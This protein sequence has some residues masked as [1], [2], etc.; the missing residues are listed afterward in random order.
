MFEEE[1]RP[2]MPPTGNQ[3]AAADARGKDTPA[4]S[5]EAQGMKAENLSDQKRVNYAF[6]PKKDGENESVAEKTRANAGKTAVPYVR[7][8]RANTAKTNAS[9]AEKNGTTDEKAGSPIPSEKVERPA[10]SPADDKF[11]TLD[12][13]SDPIYPLEYPPEYDDS[14]APA[15]APAGIPQNAEKPQT[16][17]EEERPFE[18][19]F[20]RTAPEA[21][22][23]PIERERNNAR[24][25]AGAAAVERSAREEE[26]RALLAALA[27]KKRGDDD[28]FLSTQR[29]GVRMSA[30]KGAYEKGD[31][32]LSEEYLKSR[33]AD[34]DLRALRE[35]EA[36]DILRTANEEIEK[37]IEKRQK[38]EEE[39]QNRHA[40]KK[41]DKDDDFFRVEEPSAGQNEEESITNKLTESEQK[42]LQ[43][44]KEREE[45]REDRKRRRLVMRAGDFDSFDVSGTASPKKSESDKP[46]D[47]L[48]L[49]DYLAKR[50]AAIR[51]DNDRKRQ[52]LS[53]KAQK[54]LRKKEKA[55]AINEAV[56]SLSALGITD[57][58]STQ[59]IAKSISSARNADEVYPSAMQTAGAAGKNATLTQRIEKAKQLAYSD[60]A[61]RYLQSVEEEQQNNRA[62]LRNIKEKLSEERRL[63]R[64]DKKSNPEFYLREFEKEVNPALQAKAKGDSEKETTEAKLTAILLALEDARDLAVET[65]E[66]L[67]EEA[68]DAKDAAEYDAYASMQAS[69]RAKIERDRVEKI[70][71]HSDVSESYRRKVE[72]EALRE[73]K[74]ANLDAKNAVKAEAV[75]QMKAELLEEITAE[76]EAR[77]F[78]LGAAEASLAAEAARVEAERIAESERNAAAAALAKSEEAGARLVHARARLSLP[79]TKAEKAILEKE[80][81]DAAEIQLRS[82]REA[83]ERS[84]KADVDEIKVSFAVAK[85]ERIEAD[86]L[87]RSARMLAEK[88]EVYALEQ[89]R[90]VGVADLDHYPEAENSA[91]AAR[92]EADR[93]F[94]RVRE[95]AVRAAKAA[96]TFALLEAAVAKKERQAAERAARVA[97][98]EADIAERAAKLKEE[99][100]IVALY[101]DKKVA[102]R[103]AK[104]ARFVA[105][106]KAES[107]VAQKARAAAAA[108]NELKLTAYA[109]GVEDERL[110]RAERD[111]EDAKERAR[112]L[113]DVRAE[114]QIRLSEKTAL[115]SAEEALAIMDTVAALREARLAE[116]ER[117]D[118]SVLRDE[119]EAETDEETSGEESAEEV[120]EQTPAE[121]RR[122]L[123]IAKKEATKEADKVNIERSEAR[124]EELFAL[125]LENKIAK[126]KERLRKEEIAN[127]VALRE[128]GERRLTEAKTLLAGALRVAEEKTAA[129]IRADK[130][131]R[132]TASVARKRSANEEKTGV[133]DRVKAKALEARVQAERVSRK[134]HSAAVASAAAEAEVKARLL[135]VEE[136][137]L[138]NEDRLALNE[139]SRELGELKKE[140]ASAEKA[141]AET[142]RDAARAAA[143]LENAKRKYEGAEE[144][145]NNAKESAERILAER[146]AAIAKEERDR[147]DRDLTDKNDENRKALARLAVL[148]AKEEALLAKEEERLAARSAG[149]ALKDAVYHAVLAERVPEIEKTEAGVQAEKCREEADRKEAENRKKTAKAAKAVSALAIAEEQEAALEAEITARS[150]RIAE[151]DAKND[152]SAAIRLDF[153]ADNAQ[154]DEKTAALRALRAQRE[155]ADRSHEI[156]EVER[157]RAKRAQEVAARCHEAALH[158]EEEYL[159][160]S[161]TANA[162]IRARAETEA[163]RLSER[164]VR[165]RDRLAKLNELERAKVLAGAET[166]VGLSNA[167][168]RRKKLKDGVRE[169]ARQR[170]GKEIEKTA[171]SSEAEE[172]LTLYLE[173][174]RFYPEVSASLREYVGPIN[175]KVRK[176]TEKL[177]ET[178]ENKKYVAAEREELK[179]FVTESTAALEKVRDEHRKAE[180]RAEEEIVRAQKFENTAKAEAKRA[181]KEQA[182]AFLRAEE[183]G[184][185]YSEQIGKEE[186][187]R[188]YKWMKEARAEAEEALRFAEEQALLAE[189]AEADTLAKTEKAERLKQE[190]QKLEK[191]A[192]VD[193]EAE[194]TALERDIEARYAKLLREEAANAEKKAQA[195]REAAD[196][197]EKKHKKALDRKERDENAE[198]RAKETALKKEQAQRVAKEAAF[199]ADY[200]EAKARELSAKVER[201]A[202]EDAA[203]EARLLA[204]TAQKT[205][206]L[207]E[208][209]V[210][211]A[212]GEAKGE[213]ERARKVAQEEAE[214]AEKF[215]RRE[216][217][218]AAKALKAETEVAASVAELRKKESERQKRLAE[219]DFDRKKKEEEAAAEALLKADRK[220]KAEKAKQ[221]KEAKKEAE[222]A[223]ERLEEAKRQEEKDR[224]KAEEAEK[225]SE[226]AELIRQQRAAEEEKRSRERAEKAAEKEREKQILAEK[227]EKERAEKEAELKARREALLRSVAEDAQAASEKARP[228]VRKA[229][230][231]EDYF[232]DYVEQDQKAKAAAKAFEW[233]HRIA[234]EE[235]E[236]A[237][238]LALEARKAAEDANNRL[239]AESEQVLEVI[240]S[241]RNAAKKAERRASLKNTKEALAKERRAEKAGAYLDNVRKGARKAELAAMKAEA[242]AAIRKER[243]DRLEEEASMRT[244]SE[245]DA[246]KLRLALAEVKEAETLTATIKKDVDMA[247]EEALIAEENCL[248][249]ENRLKAGAADADRDVLRRNLAEAENT[250][251]NAEKQLKNLETIAE[252]AKLSQFA[253]QAKADRVAAVIAAT[254]ARLAAERAKVAEMS[255]DLKAQALSGAAK[256]EAEN[257][258]KI[259]TAEVGRAE[260]FAADAEKKAV[261][262]AVAE[263]EAAERSARADRLEAERIARLVSAE[264]KDA[265]NVAN[266]SADAASKAERED[267][268]EAEKKARSD[269]AEAERREEAA[270]EAAKNAERK[271]DAEKQAAKA[272]S[273]A[274]EETKRFFEDEKKVSLER[275]KTA[276]RKVA[277]KEATATGIS[278]KLTPDERKDYFDVVFKEDRRINNA[279]AENREQARR[280]ADRIESRSRDAELTKR[281]AEFTDKREEAYRALLDARKERQLQE[282]EL[283]RAKDEAEAAK[284]RAEAEKE[285]LKNAEGDEKE[286]AQREAYFA[287]REAKRLERVAL[288]E[289]QK[290][291]R[292]ASAGALAEQTLAA[293]SAAAEAAWKDGEEE[294]TDQYTSSA[295]SAADKITLSDLAKGRIGIGDKTDAAEDFLLSYAARDFLTEDMNEKGKSRK[296]K[297]KPAAE[298]V[299]PTLFTTANT[300]A[301]LDTMAGG[302]MD[303]LSNPRQA[304]A[305]IADSYFEHVVSDML[306]EIEFFSISLEQEKKRIKKQ[307]GD[308]K[309][310]AAAEIVDLERA[311]C[312]KYFDIL[313]FGKEKNKESEVTKFVPK[314]VAEIRRY[315]A[316]VKA[317]EAL[318]HQKH[319]YASLKI[320]AAILDGTAYRPMIS[321][322]YGMD[323]SEREKKRNLSAHAF[324]AD[325]S[326]IRARYNYRIAKL[327]AELKNGR[328]TY[329]AETL[330]GA[331]GKA[332]VKETRKKLRSQREKALKAEIADNGRYEAVLNSDV[333]TTRFKKDNVNRARLEHY[334]VMLIMALAERDELN[335]KLLTLYTGETPVMGTDTVISL[336]E[337]GKVKGKGSARAFADAKYDEIFTKAR[338]KQYNNEWKTA[339]TIQKLR[340]SEKTSSLL[341]HLLNRKMELAAIVSTEDKK[342]RIYGW[343]GSARKQALRETRVSKRELRK[344]SRE[345]AARLRSAKEESRTRPGIR[346]FH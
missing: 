180:R 12:F 216:E 83:I 198:R 105:D 177:S 219:K 20:G 314:A 162:G 10:P 167:E 331:F 48:V 110:S 206:I 9:A 264:A 168:N 272:A 260:Q 302:D 47:Q 32:S 81:K 160:T 248:I 346:W 265:R 38:E 305:D 130:N 24:R 341:F 26:K 131:E 125:N 226:K 175:D 139:L 220:E 173:G 254:G 329:S 233:E 172:F 137:L 193:R 46:L 252:K 229:D 259:L 75:A 87:E 201:I 190:N 76:N 242:I 97:L 144:R 152:D 191:R 183:A 114:R 203:R 35:K 138:A 247:Q 118:M 78:E 224:R 261:R 106:R 107:A 214:K 344:V 2:K 313:G 60:E 151:E 185:Y 228:N 23:N 238:K 73:E 85:E 306:T 62:A 209:R 230:T 215:A 328:Y 330:K 55:D 43:K 165:L 303:A 325:M 309:M 227:R 322:D 135:K 147:A 127:E 111:I 256:A 218:K 236:E 288:E 289:E 115:I 194:Y 134:A 332:K 100:A 234:V 337:N 297:E 71:G 52:D 54:K 336:T 17:P 186:K 255:A 296:P 282:R 117:I 300:L 333:F 5:Q 33:F 11:L 343:R 320:P 58:K 207:T 217:E 49:M 315:N 15:G 205:A 103:E 146:A 16:G 80:I 101:S 3:N 128:E 159:L 188:A 270:A 169:A 133:S 70:K 36:D 37:E 204:E 286:E 225:R 202:A 98:E 34:P 124:K 319:A 132:L 176:F 59:K 187:A 72:Q 267:F 287:L 291:E 197:A 44:G 158:A 311:V 25:A 304:E 92:E 42:T 266:A 245:E 274:E 163:R 148:K 262:A 142:E 284:K 82:E 31:P 277:E 69:Q 53:K 246:Q 68:E 64:E 283:K 184:R 182:A 140:L 258:L 232:F 119:S 200:A 94:A 208:M 123:R 30:G 323:E 21:K 66:I 141:C 240:V 40:K 61:I 93:A 39:R 281:I 22:E 178:I 298:A 273:R 156:A 338:K 91:K 239:K 145:K 241:S 154:K 210:K 99:Q 88:A 170:E 150:A 65:Q 294:P 317:L 129:S 108:Q 334:R 90:L 327:N 249:A 174:K 280:Q 181:A 199:E 250:L 340:V 122:E 269:A 192:E 290:A 221:A 57:D 109:A 339:K 4:H 345:L 112:A 86:R 41:K 295:W 56:A 285:N 243:V 213:A 276:A 235:Y 279:I 149:E 275:A 321:P 301:V 278:L 19:V 63:E 14:I 67:R 171:G 195:S 257:A 104:D 307:R 335:R 189:K 18:R 45:K 263:A 326:L 1:K 161:E 102:D 77:L 153:V 143:V 50:F 244:R 292:A 120:F 136:I 79:L 96:K 84:E 231:V 253:K 8:D 316:A 318:D 324:H 310:N 271:A 13:S 212:E 237:Q 126:Q 164:E 308:A 342:I 179:R 268:A 74:K 211:N 157:E 27:A 155:K 95:E 116:V 29:H 312:E 251:K 51:V 113:A 89:E 166:V 222:K 121:Q 7:K 293:A 28:A 223:K 196:E 6:Y 299:M